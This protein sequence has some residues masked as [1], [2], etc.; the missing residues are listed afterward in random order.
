MV[1][2]HC[3]SE[4]R[5]RR[6]EKGAQYQE[7]LNSIFKTS[8]SQ[9]IEISVLSSEFLNTSS[10][11]YLASDK[12]MPGPELEAAREAE[13]RRQEVL[14]QMRDVSDLSSRLEPY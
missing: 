1:T 2:L 4:R 10:A 8:S 14:R 13:L 7:Y 6:R 12:L 5:A 3:L 9:F 11:T